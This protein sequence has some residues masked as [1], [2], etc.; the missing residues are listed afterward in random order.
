[1][2][3]MNGL[4]ASIFFRL[5]TTSRAAFAFPSDGY[6]PRFTGDS[7]TDTIS[8]FGQIDYNLSDECTAHRWSALDP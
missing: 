1:M 6:L 5:K 8:A 3:A 4:L 7:T 2:R